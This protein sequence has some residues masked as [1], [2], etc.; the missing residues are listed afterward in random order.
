[1]TNPAIT[2]PF[3]LSLADGSRAQSA[4]VDMADDGRS[5]DQLRADAFTAAYA[6]A[7]VAFPAHDPHVAL[8]W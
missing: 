8:A 5:A 7:D 2:F 3:I 4:A 6:L 1:M